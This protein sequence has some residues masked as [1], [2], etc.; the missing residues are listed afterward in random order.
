MTDQNYAHVSIIADRSGSMG[1]IADPPLSKAQA[2]TAGIHKLIDAQLAAP[3]RVTFSLMDF[4][5]I[6]TDVESMGDGSKSLEWS[7][8]PRGMTALLDAVGTTIVKTGEQL[9]A[10]PE[11]QR[12]G[13]VFV[14]IATDGIENASHEYRLAQVKDMV[15][16]QRED[17]DW[18][19]IF[20]G[21]DIDAFGDAFA[22]GMTRDATLTTNS[23]NLSAA[24]TATNNAMLRSRGPGGQSVSYSGAERAAAS[25]GTSD[26]DA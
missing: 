12:P 20:I 13:R 4:D 9:A 21:C 15:T 24:Y 26:P 25:G 5:T 10:M 8:Q 22:M 19:F 7:C 23:A 6:H 2:A 1:H 11:D 3:G 18:Q 14:V 17:Y 16:R